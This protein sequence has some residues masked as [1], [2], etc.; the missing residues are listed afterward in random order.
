MKALRLLLLCMMSLALACSGEK[1]DDPLV[2]GFSQCTEGDAW[3]IAMREEMMRELSFYPHLQLQIKD[4]KNSSELQVQHIQEFIELGVD[5]LIVSPNEA[6]PV[7]P[8]VEEAYEKGIPVIIVDRKTNSSHYTAYVGADNY[9]IG[10]LAGNYAA[11][12]LK[13]KGN[14]LEV[15]G[16]KGSSPALHRHTGFMDAIAPFKELK[17]VAEVPGEWEKEIAR[18]RTSAAMPAEQDIQLVFA[19]NDMM[20]LGAY[21]QLK[22]Q[23]QQ[24]ELFFL[25]VDGLG[26]PDAGLML[27]E[28]SILDATFLYPTGG[29]E[30]IRLAHNILSGNPY[31]KENLL[32]S[33]VIDKRN[34]QILKQQTNKIIQQQ[35]NIERQQQKLDEQLRLYHNQRSLLYAVLFGTV[36]IIVLAALVAL[37]LRE[38][39]ELN[40]VLIAKNNE[41]I[42]QRNELARMAKKADKAT[43]AKVKFFTNVSHEFRTPLTLILAPVEDALKSNLP[44][45]VKKELE[46]V[47]KNANRLLKLVNQLMD[48]RKV[49]NKKMKL[50]ASERDLAGFIHEVTSAFYGLAAKRNIQLSIATTPSPLLLYFDADKLDKVLFNLLSNAFKFSP[51]GGAITLTA[52]ISGDNSHAILRI[53]DTGKGMTP[54]QQEHAFDRFYS[55]EQHGTL[56][57]GLGLALS[58]ELVKLHKG[59]ISVTSALGKGTSFTI[60]L[61]LGRAHLSEAE[62]VPEDGLTRFSHTSEALLAEQQQPAAEETTIQFPK[63]IREHTLLLIEDN[64]ELRQFLKEHLQHDFNVLEASDGELGI[65]LAFEMVPDL[66]LSDVMLPARSGLEVATTL[67]TDRRTSHIP[68]VLLTARDA[69]EQKIEGVQTGADLYVTKPF[70][71]QYLIERIKG[72]IKN[73]ELLKERFQQDVPVDASSMPVPKQ[74]DRKFIQEFMAVVEANVSNASLSA[75]DI[76]TNLGMSRVQVYRK[77]K[78]LL[79]NS[80]ND[81]VVNVR[82]K[83]AK[84]L[85]T[86]GELNIS[87][88]AYEVGYSSPAYFS[89]A[90]KNHF[91]QSPSDFKAEASNV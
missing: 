90:F 14:I 33:T 52:E 71:Y 9:E 48:F 66:V 8:I 81:Y 32:R 17:V 11:D 77:V 61:P 6:D 65:S 22:S 51:D 25:G 23:K 7:T 74:L 86:Q 34:V 10:K 57:T 30:T 31:E 79:G 84:Q 29:E 44:L 55:G 40:K 63:S 64:E 35:Q 13:G 89:T 4:A 85:L 18:E 50:R 69:L 54:E 5:L 36:V 1:Q 60:R 49:Q 43:E 20:A 24:Q 39:S 47:R 72:L 15:W 88:I 16:L 12:L 56:G 58:K 37:A 42:N 82:M 67:K 38:K 28:R 27:V 41:V 46:L 78:A 59:D 76:A 45:E 70:S 26:G 75:N 19:H 21:E 3:R 53:E 2:I 80:V 83:K 68:V 91:H 62:I 73:R 87:E